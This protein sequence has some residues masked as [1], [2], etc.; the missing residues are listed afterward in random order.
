M[1]HLIHRIFDTLTTMKNHHLLN[2]KFANIKS[3]SASNDNH[4]VN[5]RQKSNKN[6]ARNALFPGWR[7]TIVKVLLSVMT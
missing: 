4:E 2:Y 5:E 1:Q 3:N 6:S 7:K